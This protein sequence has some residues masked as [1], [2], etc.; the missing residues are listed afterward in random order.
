[1]ARADDTFLSIL[2][3]SHMFERTGGYYLPL[4][5]GAKVVYARGVAQIADDLAAQAPTVDVRGAAHLREVCS[6]A[7]TR[8]S[9]DS[10][11][12]RW[13]FDAV[14]CTRLAVSSRARRVARPAASRRCCARWSRGRFSRVWAAGC[15]STVVGGAALDPVHRAHVHRPRP[16]ACCKATA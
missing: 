3:L 12:K 2:P 14:R 13:L 16:A 8:R 4:S 1:M 15:A 10:P 5:L 9:S 7:S 6:L 11:L